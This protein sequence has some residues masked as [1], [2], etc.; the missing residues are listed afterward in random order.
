MYFCDVILI[1]INIFRDIFTN[2]HFFLELYIQ[3]FE[4]KFLSILCTRG[5]M[6]ST[7]GFEANVLGSNPNSCYLSFFSI[8]VNCY[9]SKLKFYNFARLNE[10]IHSEDLYDN[11]RHTSMYH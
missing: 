11:S 5:I 2:F 8:F 3:M 6:I 9:F 1:M 4:P 7:L 10:I